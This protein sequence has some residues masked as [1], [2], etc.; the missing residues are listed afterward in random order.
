MYAA[1]DYQGIE[2]YIQAEAAAFFDV[3]PTLSQ[4]P[5]AL[6]DELVPE[7]KRKA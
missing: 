3:Y 6:G 1:G 5:R 2:A 7:T 4:T